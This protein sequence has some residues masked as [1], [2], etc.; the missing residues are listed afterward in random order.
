MII[1]SA[2]NQG[3]KAVNR[4]LKQRQAWE[5]GFHLLYRHAR[6]RNGLTCGLAASGERDI[7]EARDAPRVVK[8][9][10]V[11]VPHPVKEQ[12]V[13]LAALDAQVLLHHRGMFRNTYFSAFT[14]Y[15]V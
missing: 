2:L 15:S 14:S 3:L 1:A 8:E 13:R 4:E 12:C 5:V 9:K 10:L 11:K 7:E 6:H